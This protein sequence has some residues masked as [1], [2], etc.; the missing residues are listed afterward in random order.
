MFTVSF[1]S[2]LLHIFHLQYLHDADCSVEGLTGDRAP[3]SA[4]LD[5]VLP[6]VA[7]VLVA[8]P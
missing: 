4:E 8:L 6:Y 3:G 5:L 1:L 2:R 7:T